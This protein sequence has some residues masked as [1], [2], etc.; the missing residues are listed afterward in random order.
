MNRKYTAFCNIKSFN[1]NDRLSISR[2]ASI[3]EISIAG[4]LYYTNGTIT[5]T[6]YAGNTGQRRCLPCN[7]GFNVVKGACRMSSAV[8][9]YLL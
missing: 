7:G 9:A 6:N 4:G 1:F 8:E 2:M 3:I 5:Y